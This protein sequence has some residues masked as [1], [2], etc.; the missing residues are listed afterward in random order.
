[1]S[2]ILIIDDQA[3]VR[4][5]ASIAL[6][7]QGFECVEA[8]SPLL[9]LEILASQSVSLILL[10]MNFSQDTTSGQEG[11]SFLKNLKDK[12]IQI[13]VVVMTAWASVEIA[14]QA[15][16][17]GA[18]DFIEKPWQNTRLVSIVKQQLNTAELHQENARFSELNRSTT[19]QPLATSASMVALLNKAKRAA[20]SDANILITGENG[21]GKSLLA[22][23]IHQQSARAS[24]RFV[25]VNMGAIP[26]SLF[27]SELFGH[28]KGAFTDAKE[29][30]LGRFDIASNGTLFLDEIGTLPQNLQAKMLRVLETGEYEVVGSSHTQQTNARII[31]ATNAD[32]EKLISDDDFRR[33]L[34]FRLN[35]VE[36]HIPPLRERAEDISFLAQH[37]LS[38][39]AKKYQRTDMSFSDDSLNAMLKHAWTGNI[40]ELSH[41]IE[42][43]VIMSEDKVLDVAALALNNSGSNLA[44]DWP[45]LTLDEAEKKTIIKALQYFKGNVLEAGEFLAMSKSALYRRIEKY[46]IDPNS[47]EQ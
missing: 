37:L 39:H 14:V 2:L 46:C 12:H 13:P 17:L 41:C 3:D 10:D 33:D 26:E 20:L 8:D 44:N 4:M 7:Y 21:T 5:S 30:R 28:K 38:M 23:Y 15:M 32:L 27:E 19:Q 31:S 22:R 36:L 35:T 25:S 11:L 29:N 34:L 6:N 18:V 16:Q 47:L 24:Q 42:R 9:G 45:L 43:A 1:M 40:R